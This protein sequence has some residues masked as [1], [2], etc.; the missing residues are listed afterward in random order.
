MSI[1]ALP[2]TVQ[3]LLDLQDSIQFFTNEAQATSQA[4]AI[5]GGTTTVYDYALQLLD[6]NLATSQVAMAVP[7]LILNETPAVDVL[8]N[9]SL[10][11]LPAQIDF[12]ISQGL[13]PVVYAA[14]T[15]AVNAANDNAAA[16]DALYGALSATQFATVVSTTTGVNTTAILQFI[17]NWEDFYTNNPNAIPA[18]LDVQSA[19]YAAAFGDAIG[20]ALVDD[21]PFTQSVNDLT[22]NALLTIATGQYV[23]GVPITSLPDHAPLQGE[24]DL[25]L[26]IGVDHLSTSAPDQVFDATPAA[27]PPFGSDNTLN[28]GDTLTDTAG[29][30]TINFT[31]AGGLGQFV[32]NPPFALGVNM[33]GIQTANILHAFPLLVPAGFAGNITGLTEVHLLAG[34][35][36]DIEL[37]LPTNGLHT[38]LE[39]IIIDSTGTILSLLPDLEVWMDGAGFDGTQEVQLTLNGVGALDPVE[40]DLE[41]TTGTV[42]YGA[43]NVTSATGPNVLELDT[44]TMDT[45]ATVNVDGDQNLEIFGS[46]LDQDTLELFD[47]SV[48]SGDIDATFAPGTGGV[49]AL[50]GS[51]DDTFTWQTDDGDPTTFTTADSVDGGAGDNRLRL[52]AD[53]GVLLAVGVGAAIENIQT[54]EHFTNGGADGDI[55]VDM[56][57]SG[58][59]TE[60]DLQGNYGYIPGVAPFIVPVSAGHDVTV[61]ELTNQ[62]T[63]T[64]T[65]GGDGTGI[66]NLTLEHAGGVGIIN[67]VMSQTSVGGT[68]T[69]GEVHIPTATTLL[70]LASEG[71][72]DLNWITDASDVTG[73]V[74]ITGDVDLF[75]VDP[76]D[77]NF[78]AYDQDNGVIDASAFTGHLSIAVG[79]GSQQVFGG[80][81]DDFIETFSNVGVDIIHLE[82]G[83]ADAVQFENPF[84]GDNVDLGGAVALTEAH[85]ITGFDVANDVVQIDVTNAGWSLVDT[86][87]APLTEADNPIDIAVFQTNQVTN[88]GIFFPYEMVKLTSP[89]NTAGL[90]AEQG[91]TVGVGV[92]GS[93]D[94]SGIGG[95]DLLWAYYDNTHEQ[96]VLGF[97]NGVGGDVT[98]ADDYDVIALIGMS[99]AD[100]NAF[101]AANLHIVQD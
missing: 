32:S 76:A 69:V 43:V 85:R 63:V 17:N 48:A 100:Y 68:L 6:A 35:V 46:V 72:A 28:T 18:N 93:F 19:S 58:S 30:G 88:V 38:P 8:A 15:W 31:T 77:F 11:F 4:A 62:D 84:N 55:S 90:D 3:D 13:D 27:N 74:Q 29:D 87:G 52:Q 94:T 65:A 37:G 95:N 20:N 54:I 71:N 57:E 98:S 9:V 56:S 49:A 21:S 66:N 25:R 60:L 67:F 86:L 23:V 92:G 39:N 16:F 12:A 96:M 83:G 1:Y 45:I 24:Q 50:G 7:S 101:S 99:Q 91:F 51:G 97:V 79:D 47:A 10:N 36:G 22:E 70:N 82:A 61:T 2:V 59:A 44:D 5:N 73:N 81:N 89:V 41:V 64:F 75:F 33:D 42:G 14:E 80:T 34:N 78:K 40:V 26:T 53:T